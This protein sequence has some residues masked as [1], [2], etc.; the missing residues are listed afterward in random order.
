MS[1]P[2]VEETE[3]EATRLLVLSMKSSI[4]LKETLSDAPTCTVYCPVIVTG[5]RLLFGTGALNQARGS[6]RLLTVTLIT[7]AVLALLA[8]SVAVAE[9]VCDALV[10]L[11]VSQ[12]QE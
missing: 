2:L 8:A 10:A 6:G 9:I 7:G 12:E 5:E 11:V 1:V 4:R 3:V